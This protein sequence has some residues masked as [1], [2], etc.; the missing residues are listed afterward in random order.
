MATDFV[1]VMRECLVSALDAAPLIVGVTGR[2]N[3]NTI[4]WDDLATGGALPIVAYRIT[5]MHPSG[6]LGDERKVHITFKAVAVTEA[7][8]NELLGAIEKSLTYL[9]LRDAVPS[10]AAYRLYGEEDRVAADYDDEVEAQVADFDAV[11]VASN[12][13]P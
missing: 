12:P 6:G 9:R 2:A 8:A 5:T 3:G 7:Q 4:A 1:Q 10:V 11:L 13:N